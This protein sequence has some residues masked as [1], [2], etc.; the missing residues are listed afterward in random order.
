MNF[1]PKFAEDLRI[2]YK[3]NL[4]N[5]LRPNSPPIRLVW[6]AGQPNFG[7]ALSPILVMVLSGRYVKGP[8]GNNPPLL[9]GPRLF[10]LGSSLWKAKDGDI[11]WGAGLKATEGF[12]ARKLQVFAVRGPLTREGLLARGID[13]PEVY[14][15]PAILMPYIYKP[16]IKRRLGIGIV[17]HFN[18]LTDRSQF[19]SSEIKII[20]V[21]DHPLRVIELINSCE[22]VLSSSLHGIII[23]EAYGIPACWVYPTKE[24]WRASIPQVEF[25]YKDYYLSTGREPV[26]F[27]HSGSF[28][29][30]KAVKIAL[31]TDKPKYS[32]EKLLQAFPFRREDIRSLDEL[33]RYEIK[34]VVIEVPSLQSRVIRKVKSIMWQSAY[35]CCFKLRRFK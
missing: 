17:F 22:V 15:D 11:I 19:K 18:D 32:P 33:S 31:N 2:I 3:N 6:G 12:T 30:D 28:D 21:C 5:Q 7:D 8:N 20:N 9:F 25:K 13:C 27:K 14:G 23:A 16:R 24:V 1:Y 10:A 29:I 26:F 34:D 4:F 35:K